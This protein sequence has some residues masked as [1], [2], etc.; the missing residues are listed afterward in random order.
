[1]DIISF[2]TA[3]IAPTLG[4]LGIRHQTKMELNKIQ[5]QKETDLDNL[6]SQIQLEIEKYE[7]SKQVDVTY[8]MFHK[9]MDDPT[10]VQNLNSN[11]QKFL[12]INT[13]S[14]HPALKNKRR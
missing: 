12:S 14:K 2:A 13:N 5:K 7:K 10:A 4:Y 9:L 1:M 6:K 3:I 8:D 11:L